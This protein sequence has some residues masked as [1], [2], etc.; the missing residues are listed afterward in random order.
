MIHAL[1]GRAPLIVMALLVLAGGFAPFVRNSILAQVRADEPKDEGVRIEYRGKPGDIYY[2]VIEND[3][4]DDVAIHT[5]MFRLPSSTTFKDRRTVIQTITQPAPVNNNALLRFEWVVD[6]YSASE[7][8]TDMAQVDFDSLK[9]THPPRELSGLAKV[10]GAKAGFDF[11]G[12]TGAVSVMRVQPGPGAHPT[13]S[14][15]SKTAENGLVT[16]ENMQELL[17]SMGEQFLPGA[18]KRVG[19]QWVIKREKPEPPF[20]TIT[21]NTTCKLRSLETV[22]G[23]EIANI[24][25]TGVIFFKAAPVKQ[26]V[27]PQVQPPVVVPHPTTRPASTTAPHH[28]I[29]PQSPT[30]INP[31]TRAVPRHTTPPIPRPTTRPTSRP[32]DRMQRQPHIS[33]S[34]I[35]TGAMPSVS[36]MPGL[37]TIPSPA[38]LNFAV[39]TAQ[40][41]QPD[42]N[43]NESKKPTSSP[44]MRIVQSQ[45][46][47]EKPA[48]SM[49]TPPPPST[50]STKTTEEPF[51]MPGAH[52]SGSIKF[53]VTNGRLIELTIRSNAAF[54]KVMRSDKEEMKIAQG[55]KRILRIKGSLTP[56]PQPNIPGGKKPPVE[57]ALPNARPTVQPSTTTRPAAN[58]TSQPVVNAPSRPMG[59]A[60]TRPAPTSPGAAMAKPTSGMPKTIA[61][62]AAT[63]QPQP[64]TATTQPND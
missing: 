49:P 3:I 5:Q 31:T 59:S 1:R 24:D 20:G 16:P 12:K 26:P 15:Q 39:A 22:N 21:T 7:V 41:P 43:G 29:T 62:R 42:T 32:A 23:T 57:K 2:Y 47:D 36:A 6:R 64:P 60:A 58:S 50:P 25:L 28:S 30:A 37:N 61:P 33:K 10:P 54:E 55:S 9:H 18:P 45:P 4:T 51:T 35:P 13:D 48:T 17:Y 63:S 56:P 44:V 27:A 38:P 34:P 53:D 40:D 11:D 19:D 46:V 8:V 14:R 52:F